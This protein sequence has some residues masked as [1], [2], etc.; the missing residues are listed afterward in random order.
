MIHLKKLIMKKNVGNIDRAV[1]VLLAAV[2]ITLF[3]L[4]KIEGTLGIVLVVLGSV[5]A[6]TSFV[7]FCP[8]YS[9]FGLSTCPVKKTN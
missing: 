9:L 4:G 5:F 8:L 6:L 7:G 2:F 1:R 3:A